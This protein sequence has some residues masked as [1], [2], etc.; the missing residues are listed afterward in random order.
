M[1]T[2]QPAII[3]SNC[4]QFVYTEQKYFPSVGMKWKV[5][6]GMTGL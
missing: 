5:K 6:P 4:K 1:R 2:V 3:D